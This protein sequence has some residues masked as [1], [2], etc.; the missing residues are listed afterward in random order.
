MSAT[1][2]GCRM[3]F[4]I[5]PTDSQRVTDFWSPSSGANNESVDLDRKRGGG[6]RLQ[7]VRH[8]EEQPGS[9]VA[10]YQQRN[11]SLRSWQRRS[12]DHRQVP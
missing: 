7:C 5:L 9:T 8:F 11:R 3:F 10:S 6:V 4:D 12:S 1:S 2:I